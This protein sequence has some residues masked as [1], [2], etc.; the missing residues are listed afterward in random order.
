MTTTA[1]SLLTRNHLFDSAHD[2]LLGSDIHVG[3]TRFLASLRDLRAELPP[4]DWRT[5]REQVQSHPLHRLFLESPFT[6]RAFTKPRGYAG[7][8]VLM[9]LIYGA[10]VDD[11]DLS[12]LGGMIY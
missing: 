1:V 5:F 11:A 2:A 7:D 12:P 6:R 3:I 8:A 10:A 9:D 4:E